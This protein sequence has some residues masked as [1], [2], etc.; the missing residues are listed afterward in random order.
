MGAPE[1]GVAVSLGT[2]KY[3]MDEKQEN[4]TFLGALCDYHLRVSVGGKVGAFRLA[5]LI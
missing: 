3:L 4:C 2:S 5:A 1:V